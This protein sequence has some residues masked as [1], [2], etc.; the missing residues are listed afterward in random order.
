[1]S[2]GVYLRTITIVSL[3]KLWRMCVIVSL[4]S[5]RVF[6]VLFLFAFCT[7]LARTRIEAI[8]T[9]REAARLSRKQI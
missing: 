7:E 1:M 3:W 9:F 6:A 4:A 2:I 5:V 8:T